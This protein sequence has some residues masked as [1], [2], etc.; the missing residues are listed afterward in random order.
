M[1][2]VI[3]AVPE[4]GR[5]LKALTVGGPRGPGPERRDRLNARC[6]RVATL[7]QGL[8][9]ARRTHTRIAHSE[10]AISSPV[11]GSST[12]TGSSDGGTRSS[13]GSTR[14]SRKSGTPFTFK[15]WRSKRHS[16]VRPRV[17]YT[18]R[19]GAFTV[20]ESAAMRPNRW[21][22]DLSHLITSDGTLVSE[23]SS[24]LP[25]Y[26]TMLVEAATASPAGAWIASPVRCRLRPGR[27]RCPGHTHVS[28]SLIESDGGFR[29][30][31][32]RPS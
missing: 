31:N 1:R 8:R 21:A 13:T 29:V 28:R 25:V 10:G 12:R 5:C 9:G 27:K 6:I 23:R 17:A 3:A 14:A 26:L 2:L 30:G 20:A 22:T 19:P 24:G 32:I 16:D 4:P 15:S 11:G 18:H 7:R